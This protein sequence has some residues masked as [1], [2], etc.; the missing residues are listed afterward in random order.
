MPISEKTGFK[1]TSK[2]KIKIVDNNELRKEI[3]ALYEK[4]SHVDLAKWSL[5]I[6]KHIF[7]S[8]NIDYNVI[9]A[10][11]NGFM[12]NELWQSGNARVH[13]RACNG[14]LMN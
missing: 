13:E 9:E 3:D 1:M 8:A 4:T 12:V 11:T 10:V 2:V 5:S 6:A 14:S 7:N